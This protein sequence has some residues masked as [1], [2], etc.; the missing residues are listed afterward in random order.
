MC[1]LHQACKKVG[2]RKPYGK[3][4]ISFSVVYSCTSVE[5]LDQHWT[6]EGKGPEWNNE[7]KQFFECLDPDDFPD[8]DLLDVERLK[9]RFVR[10]LNEGRV[11]KQYLGPHGVKGLLYPDED[12]ADA[13]HLALRGVPARLGT[14]R[15]RAQS[16]PRRPCRADPGVG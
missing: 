16:L 15:A 10:E 5:H 2:A 6:Q 4:D 8:P 13:N 12:E 14:F 1:P 11:G 3:G 7:A 9:E